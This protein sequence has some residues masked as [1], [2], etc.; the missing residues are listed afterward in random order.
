MNSEFEARTGWNENEEALLE[1]KVAQARRDNRPLRSVFGEVALKT[2]RAPNSI[3]NHYYL[4]VREEN[5]PLAAYQA[6]AAFVPF[7]DEEIRALVKHVLKEQARGIS[8][9]A[10]TLSLGEGDNKAMLRYQNK[11][12]AVLRNDKELIKELV[13]EL[14]AEGVNAFDPSERMVAPE[15][16]YMGRGRRSYGAARAAGSADFKR[17]AGFFTELSRLAAGAA[18]ELG[19]DMDIS[20]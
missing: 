9:R 15:G 16:A 1:E 7:T 11:Y 14:K 19:K 13:E 20:L 3:R 17:L 2:G 12:R 8:V 10:C 6:G 18:M 5:S 4:K